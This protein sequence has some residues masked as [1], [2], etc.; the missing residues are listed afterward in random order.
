MHQRSLNLFTY[1]FTPLLLKKNMH[2]RSLNLFT[3]FFTPLLLKE[4]MHK[5]SLTL[6]FALALAF[7]SHAQHIIDIKSQPGERWWGGLR[8]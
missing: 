6:I 5:R 8:L 4:N 2:K 7:V 3:Y 1:S